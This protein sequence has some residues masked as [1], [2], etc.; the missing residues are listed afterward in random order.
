MPI[1]PHFRP[2]PCN[3]MHVDDEKSLFIDVEN[4]FSFWEF[5]LKSFR[6]LYTSSRNYRERKTFE[7]LPKLLFTL[8]AAKKSKESQQN[9]HTLSNANF[10]DAFSNV[11]R[12]NSLKKI[13]FIV[14]RKTCHCLY[15][16][17]IKLIEKSPHL[18]CTYTCARIESIFLLLN[19]TQK[20]PLEHF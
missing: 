13:S 1:F 18:C 19:L 7:I 5:S 15:A 16:I 8:F 6:C 12:W 11:T 14:P 3:M 20:N 17:D 9:T 4:V 10:A 2:T